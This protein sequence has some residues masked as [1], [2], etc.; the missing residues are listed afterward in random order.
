MEIDEETVQKLSSQVDTNN[1]KSLA[2]LF[3]QLLEEEHSA[4]HQ[5]RPRLVSKFTKIIDDEQETV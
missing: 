5:Y 1:H 3:I 2:E 4:R